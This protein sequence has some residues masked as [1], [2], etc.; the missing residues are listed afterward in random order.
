MCR[1]SNIVDGTILY[2]AFQH[3]NNALWV[4]LDFIVHKT[5][6]FYKQSKTYVFKAL[7]LYKA[8]PSKK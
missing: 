2:I 3:P 8:N 5:V 6:L 1:C 7:K 4:E